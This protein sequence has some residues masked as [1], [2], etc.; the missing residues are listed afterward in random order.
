MSS[1]SKSS[2][3][4]VN[5]TQFATMLSL[6]ACTIHRMIARDEIIA[7]R[8]PGGRKWIINVERSLEKMQSEMES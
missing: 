7:F 5:V 3:K 8:R 4:F 1:I 2:E 6:S